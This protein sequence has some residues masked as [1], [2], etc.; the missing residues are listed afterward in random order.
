MICHSIP[1]FFIDEAEKFFDMADAFTKRYSFDGINTRRFWE[2]IVE[3]PE[4]A[5]CALRLFSKE[6]L[7]GSYIGMKWYSADTCVWENAAGGDI[8]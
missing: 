1:V 2:F 6:G 7:S 3:N 4:A 5:H 8:W